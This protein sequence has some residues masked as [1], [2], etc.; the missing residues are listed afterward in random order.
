MAAHLYFQ[1]WGPETLCVY[2]KL[3]HRKLF[4]KLKCQLIGNSLVVQRLGLSRP[5]QVAQVWGTSGLG[6]KILQ[7]QWYGQKLKKKKLFIQ[8]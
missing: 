5:L 6:T 2:A 7:V 4:Q 3:T 8:L 1:L